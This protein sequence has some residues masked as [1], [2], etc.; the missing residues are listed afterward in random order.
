M[1]VTGRKFRDL[2]VETGAKEIEAIESVDTL[3]RQP[4]DLLPS[5]AEIED[6][7]QD[8]AE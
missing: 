4:T 1:L 7:R 5:P 6:R 8:A 3:A 2:N